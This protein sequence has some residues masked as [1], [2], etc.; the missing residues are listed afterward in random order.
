MPAQATI[1]PFGREDLTAVAG[2]LGGHLPNRPAA[3]LAGFLRATLLDDPWADPELPSL[4]A[5]HDGRIVGFIARQP[6]R[7]ELDGEPLPAVCCSHLTVAPDERAAGLAPRLA[8]ACLDGPQRLTVSDS[9]GDVVVRLWRVLGGD[10]D[11]ARA[12]EWMVALRPARWAA[13]A[14]RSLVGR[15][16]L[17]LPVG[18][19]PLQALWQRTLRRGRAATAGVEAIDADG[20][21]LAEQLEAL[22]SRMRLRPV[23]DGAHL[24]H[25]L[26]TVPATGRTLDARV[27]RRGGQAIGA[28]A[29]TARPGGIAQVLALTARER[30]GAEVLGTLTHAAYAAGATVLAG[31]L[32]PHVRD[33]VRPRGPALGLMRLPV[34]HT[35][36]D[37]VRAA[38]ASTASLVPKLEGEWWVP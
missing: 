5:E 3:D 35:R 30:C 14:A 36:D 12:C 31:R 1:R 20:A 23:A 11:N 18:S 38:L 22:S 33:V 25:V 6:R 37:A 4:V 15:H 29:W 32:E 21:A 2:L 16:A 24:A 13:G 27:V 19:V 17:E 10:V 34:F 9:A 7:M 8:V 28:W 26:A